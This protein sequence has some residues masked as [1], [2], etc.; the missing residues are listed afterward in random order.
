MWQ[1]YC[2]VHLFG[3]KNSING[4]DRFITRFSITPKTNIVNL[5]ITLENF[6]KWLNNPWFYL[7]LFGSNVFIVSKFIIILPMSVIFV[8]CSGKSHKYLCLLF[9][10]RLQRSYERWFTQRFATVYSLKY[11]LKLKVIWFSIQANL[12]SNEMSYE[13]KLHI[14]VGSFISFFQSKFWWMSFCL[15]KNN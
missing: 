4:I 12:D 6:P 15:L 2:N 8:I 1:I 14:G 9:W 7:A 5:Q 13:Y 11:P 10:I 3:I